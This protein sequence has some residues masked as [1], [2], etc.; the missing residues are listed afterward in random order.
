V[1]DY[2]TIKDTVQETVIKRSRF[3][4]YAYTLIDEDDAEEKIAFLR[5]KH[6]DA[7]HVCYAYISDEEGRRGRYSDDGEPSG[8]AGQPMF[9]ALKKSGITKCL[10][11]VVRYFG[12]ILLG[13]G[14]LVRAYSSAVSEV[15]LLAEKVTYEVKDFYSVEFPFS[16]YKKIQTGLA[17]L[18][19]VT[20]I[21]YGMAVFIQIATEVGFN[22]SDELNNLCAT[23]MEILYEGE[24]FYTG[25]KQ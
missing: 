10:V 20:K 11:A 23:K 2:T 12:G 14:G 22:F 6:Y 4:A 1:K 18:G 16:L 24:G 17:R 3:I 15:L 5:K 7:T 9:D 21:E 8:T 25:G 13:A 19:I